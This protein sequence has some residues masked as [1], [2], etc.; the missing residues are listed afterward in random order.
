MSILYDKAY[1]K[2]NYHKYICRAAD[3]CEM[4]GKI[5]TAISKVKKEHLIVR[6]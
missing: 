5:S 4:I 2:R 1:N 3:D 6:V